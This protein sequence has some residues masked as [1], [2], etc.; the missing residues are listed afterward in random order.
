MS[1][2]VQ[3]KDKVQLISEIVA[4]SSNIYFNITDEPKIPL[5]Y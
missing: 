3:F 4:Y 1:L 2:S 5:V